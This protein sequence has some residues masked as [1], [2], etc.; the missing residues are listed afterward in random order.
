MTI[1]GVLGDRVNVSND[2]ALQLAGGPRHRTPLHIF[3]MNKNFIEIIDRSDIS[4]LE[5]SGRVEWGARNKEPERTSEMIESFKI[6]KLT[7]F[8]L[9][10]EPHLGDGCVQRCTWAVGCID[11]PSRY[12]CITRLDSCRW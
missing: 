8:V 1:T 7:N 9:S 3:G 2:A 12:T 5:F 6:S 11:N 4:G 10:C